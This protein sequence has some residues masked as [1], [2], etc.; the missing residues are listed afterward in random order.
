MNS[1]RASRPLWVP[2][3]MGSD[4]LRGS[5]EG[6]AVFLVKVALG[7]DVEVGLDVFC[8]AGAGGGE[9]REETLVVGSKEAMAQDGPV[10]TW[11]GRNAVTQTQCGYCGAPRQAQY[12][13]KLPGGFVG[14]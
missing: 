13:L 9:V 8:A 7:K 10:W 3:I 6:V 4:V 1:A 14:F 5:A 12:T 11:P 2:R